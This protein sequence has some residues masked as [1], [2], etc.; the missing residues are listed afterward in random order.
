M[1]TLITAT[2]IRHDLDAARVADQ[3]AKRVAH[4]EELRVQLKLRAEEV[5]DVYQLAVANGTAQHWA[6]VPEGS[7]PVDLMVDHWIAKERN[8]FALV[9]V[10]ELPQEGK[11]FVLVYGGVDDSAVIQGTGPFETFEAAANWFYDGGR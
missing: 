5:S 8:H 11:R 1:S 2:N 9:R 10:I 6:H 3:L 4:F 7:A